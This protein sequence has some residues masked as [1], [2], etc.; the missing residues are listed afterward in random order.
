[1]NRP[2]A[3]LCAATLFAAMLAAPVAAAEKTAPELLPQTTVFYAELTQP[4]EFLGLVLEHPLRERVEGIDGVQ[5]ALKGNEYL[6]LKAAVAI[7]EAQLGMTWREAAEKLVAGGI[8][9]GLDSETQGVAV[10][11]QSSDADALN[12]ILD[13]LL[14]MARADAQNK[15]LEDPIRSTDHRGITAHHVGQLHFAAVGEWLVLT[16]H[17]SLGTQI[18]DAYL[19]GNEQALNSAA[20]Y[21]AARAGSSGDETAWSVVNL[22][23]LRKAGAAQ[24]LFKGQADNVAGE[25]LVGGLLDNLEEAPFATASLR[26]TER[27]VH[28]TLSMPYENGWIGEA[29]EYYFGPGGTGDA[30]ELIAVPSLLFSLSTYRDMSQMWLRAGDLLDEQANDE[31]AKADS[32]LSTFFAGKDFGEEILGAFRPE[33]QVVATRQS[34]QDV[35]PQPAI[36]LPAFALI[37]RLHEPERMQPELRRTFESLIGF[38]NVV[39]AMNGQPQFDLDRESENEHQI[40]TATYVP[41]ATEKDSQRAKI[42]FNFSPSVA[43]ARDCFVVSSTKE[44]ARQL[45][46]RAGLADAAGGATM[47]VNTAMNLQIPV[48]REILG[49]N[50][51]QLIARNMLE[52]GNSRQQA[53]QQIEALLAVSQWIRDLT[54]KLSVNDKALELDARLGLSELE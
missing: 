6:Q 23:A 41:E 45:A 34:F 9:F 25:V 26:L 19:D 1:M 42:H 28:L 46:D 44:L 27:Q 43:F 24:E 14:R 40:I 10:L 2:T 35:L 47:V 17:E 53:E 52:D 51:E 16:N 50:R 39:G 37:F 8:Y 7:A 4:N 49:D 30:P 29:R 48:L 15:S 13:T 32:N 3:F 20:Y 18:L 11:V 5:N 21:Q 33:I 36:K 38:L 54:F 12:N 22:E 31:L